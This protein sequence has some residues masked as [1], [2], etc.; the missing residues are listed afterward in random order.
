MK[1]L[2]HHHKSYLREIIK[3]MVAVLF[4]VGSAVK[5]ALALAAQIFSL[6]NLWLMVKKNAENKI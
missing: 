6:V 2:G 1:L 5:N 3:E 4:T